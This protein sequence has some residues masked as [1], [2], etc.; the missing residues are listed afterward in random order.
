[1]RGREFALL[2]PLGALGLLRSSAPEQGGIPGFA[3]LGMLRSFHAA[4]EGWRVCSRGPPYIGVGVDDPA[5]PAARQCSQGVSCP[6]AFG[7][8]RLKNS[9][10]TP[11]PRR[12]CDNLTIYQ[13]SRA[14]LCLRAPN[15]ISNLPGPGSHA[16]HPRDG[17]ASRAASASRAPSPRLLGQGCGPLG[18]PSARQ[19]FL[20]S[21]CPP[22]CGLAQRAGLPTAV[23]RRV[24]RRISLKPQACVPAPLDGRPGCSAFAIALCNRCH[25][26]TRYVTVKAPI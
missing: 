3:E 6:R 14:S 1:M 25:V 10:T 4:A 13:W 7:D 5:T 20:R 16:F 12:W 22:F 8:G 15:P 9:L 19:I 21:Y 23:C 2:G 26:A 24:I 18:N 11:L 17:L